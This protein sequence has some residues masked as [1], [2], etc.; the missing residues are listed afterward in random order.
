MQKM[1]LIPLDMANAIHEYLASKPMREVENLV[2]GL[3][4]LQEF[5]PPA[6]EGP[7][8]ATGGKSATE[9]AVEPDCT[10]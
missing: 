2:F 6:P 8:A 10:P 7:M 1:F 3:R 4:G 9:K 5:V